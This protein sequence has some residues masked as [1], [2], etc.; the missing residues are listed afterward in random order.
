M[1]IFGEKKKFAET[2]KLKISNDQISPEN[3]SRFLTREPHKNC[4]LAQ[5]QFVN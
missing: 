1:K 2:L 3:I 5:L 4:G